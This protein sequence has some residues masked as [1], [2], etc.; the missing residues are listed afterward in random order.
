MIG[1]LARRSEYTENKAMEQ[2][3]PRRQR[4]SRGLTFADHMDRFVTGQGAPRTLERAEMLTRV[5]PTLDRPVILF[6]DVIQILY[7]GGVGSCR[8]SSLAA[9][10]TAMAG[11]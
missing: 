11:G 3:D 2:T 9:W 6:Q 8:A 1:N 7:G 4:T 10:S 5:D